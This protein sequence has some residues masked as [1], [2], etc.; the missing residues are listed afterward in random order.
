VRSR[1]TYWP[2]LVLLPAMVLI[3]MPD[4]S[5]AADANSCVTCHTD[6]VKLKGLVKPPRIG[7]EGEG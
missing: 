5:P 2:L 1:M 6:E 7:G 3:P 4:F